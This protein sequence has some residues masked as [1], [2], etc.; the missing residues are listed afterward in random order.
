MDALEDDVNTAAAMGHLFNMIRIAG[1]VLE[2][3]SSATTREAATSSRH[4]VTP[5][6][7]GIPCSACSRKSR[8]TSSPPCVKSAPAARDWT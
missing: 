7:N 1:R 2:D 6:R 3:K 8:K 5:P 4:S